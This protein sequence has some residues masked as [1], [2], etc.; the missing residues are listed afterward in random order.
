[1]QSKAS[2]KS[3]NVG[4]GIGTTIKA[5]TELLLR[6][7]GSKLP[8]KYEPAGTT[9]VTN[10]IGCPKAAEKDLGFKWTIDLEDGM[11]SLIDWR[12]NDKEALEAKRRHVGGVATLV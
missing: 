7:T 2:G 8:I 9:F 11:R 3:Y 10:R 6:E 12:K 5:L 1:M 4:R